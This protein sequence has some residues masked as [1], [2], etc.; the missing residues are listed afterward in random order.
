MPWQVPG[1]E[2]K[3]VRYYENLPLHY[4]GEIYSVQC[5]SPATRN[6]EA[7]PGQDPGWRTLDRGGAIGTQQ[8]S[9]IVSRLELRYLPIDATRLVW[10]DRLFH[11]TFD[12]CGTFAWWDPTVLAPERIDPVEKPDYCAP[13]GTADC[14]SMDF[15]S[16]R[17]PSYEDV[18]VES[19]GRIRF[20]VRT[21]AFR[22]VVA[23]HVASDDFGRTWRVDPIA[24]AP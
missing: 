15:E 19:D 13:K 20:V 18:H 10:L 12:G 7:L 23:L 1:Y 14:R 16:D 3:V 11:V 4:S 6:L 8:A 21:P 5:Q 9:D 17:S 2:L 22:G 24:G